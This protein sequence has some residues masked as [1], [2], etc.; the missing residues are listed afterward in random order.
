VRQ[1]KKLTKR[2][3][4]LLSNH[5]ILW[6]TKIIETTVV[7]ECWKR[8]VTSYN[9]HIYSVKSI[10]IPLHNPVELNF[11][12]LYFFHTRW[13]GFR[14]NA[15]PTKNIFYLLFSLFSLP[16]LYYNFYFS[17][18][19]AWCGNEN[20]LIGYHDYFNFLLRNCINLYIYL[21]H[22]VR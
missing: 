9:H 18:W 3:I 17:S 1:R 12:F 21:L 19:N 4:K 7:Y 10:F 16:S 13:N 22:D 15:S 2:I 11:P 20:P 6:E 8:G 14:G 5:P